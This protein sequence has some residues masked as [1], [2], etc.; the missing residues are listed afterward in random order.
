MSGRN[1]RELVWRADQM[2]GARGSQ[3]LRRVLRPGP[4]DNILHLAPPDHVPRHH[5][6]LAVELR[7]DRVWVATAGGVAVLEERH[8]RV[9]VDRVPLLPHETASGPVSAQQNEIK[10]A[11]G[12]GTWYQLQSPDLRKG[13]S[14]IRSKSRE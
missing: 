9:A 13:S 5:Q 6:I 14:F 7:D 2:A 10:D 3:E 11:K 12:S 8:E 4:P 1:G